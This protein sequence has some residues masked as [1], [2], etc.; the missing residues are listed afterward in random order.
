MQLLLDDGKGGF[1]LDEEA[2]RSVVCQESVRHRKLVVLS[3]VGEFR[4][5]KS[6]LLNFMVRYLRAKCSA[7][8]LE[9][10]GQE[11]LEGFTWRRDPDRV[12]TG[13]L[14][15]PEAFL[16]KKDFAVVLLDTQGT[17]DMESNMEQNSFIFALSTLVSSIQIVNIHERLQMDAFLNLQ[18]FVE[19]GKNIAKEYGKAAFQNLLILIRDWKYPDKHDFGIRGGQEYW[20][21]NIRVS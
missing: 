17:F 2:L 12:T 9:S 14:I 8:W 3:V 1:R 19:Y 7:D 5:G 20:T 18:Y 11:N 6:F 4:R 16:V 13:I 10:D 15:W 21:D